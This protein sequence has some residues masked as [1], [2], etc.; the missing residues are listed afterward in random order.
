[1]LQP[2]T[3]SMK[4]RQYIMNVKSKTD[5]I[6]YRLLVEN[7][8]KHTFQNPYFFIDLQNKKPIHLYRFF[9]V[10]EVTGFE[11][12]ASWSQ[13]KRSTKLSHTSI[14]VGDVCQC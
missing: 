4:N 13:T 1:M 3:F 12:A 2:F 8:E 5:T 11:P 6:L 9:I 7:R 10:V 14:F